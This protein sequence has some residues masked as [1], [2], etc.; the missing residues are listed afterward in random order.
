MKKILLM[1]FSTTLMS[2]LYGQESNKKLDFIIVVDEQ[3]VIGTVSNLKLILQRDRKDDIV[4]VYYHPG[5]LEIPFSGY[6]KML[7]DVI[8][9]L[10]IDFTYYEYTGQKQKVYHYKIE[11]KKL[12]LKESFVI[13]KIYNLDKKKYKNDFQPLKGRNYTFEIDSP[14]Y[15]FRRIR[16]K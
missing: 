13:L 14:S 8:D 11:L 9:S 5:S 12:W 10:Y 6:E 15:T 3:I 7:S 2:V 1:L 4:K 16:E